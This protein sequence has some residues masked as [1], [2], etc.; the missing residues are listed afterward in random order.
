[1]PV[2]NGVL[3]RGVSV[4]AVSV[5]LGTVPAGMTWLVKE[6]NVLNGGGAAA[7][8]SVQAQNAANTMVARPYTNSALAAGA[9]ERY[10]GFLAMGPGDQLVLYPGAANLFVWAS[11]A[12]L[13]GHL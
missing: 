8:I 1:M 11:G 6:I 4:G 2:R 9:T 7:S 12:Q 5:V 3:C 13:D 10:S